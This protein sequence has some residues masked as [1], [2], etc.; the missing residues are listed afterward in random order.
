VLFLS[1]VIWERNP[2]PL[3][4]RSTLRECFCVVRRRRLT[5]PRQ[6]LHV[7]APAVAESVTRDGWS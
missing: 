2:I 6:L 1:K 4:L 7:A 3:R 5:A